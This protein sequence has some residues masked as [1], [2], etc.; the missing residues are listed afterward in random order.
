MLLFFYTI[1]SQRD[2]M[3][4][5]YFDEDMK[6]AEDTTEET[7]K[8]YQDLLGQLTDEQKQ[9]VMRTIGLKMEELKAQ[10]DM[11]KESLRD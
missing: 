1:F 10:L 8:M 6:D 11:I 7:L 9:D 2:S 5:V 3:E 4:S